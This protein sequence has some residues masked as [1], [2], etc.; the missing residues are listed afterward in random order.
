LFHL[1]RFYAPTQAYFDQSWPPP[2]D[3]TPEVNGAVQPTPSS[4]LDALGGAKRLAADRYVAEAAAGRRG[5]GVGGMG[6]P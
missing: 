3:R 1:V 5:S 2:P 6:D 4:Q